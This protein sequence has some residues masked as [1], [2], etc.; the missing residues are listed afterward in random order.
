MSKIQMMRM[1]KSLTDSLTPIDK[2]LACEDGKL[3]RL[4]LLLMLMQRKV[5]TTVWVL[6]WKLKFGHEASLLLRL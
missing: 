2:T 5:L 1:M 3:L 4:L 6:I